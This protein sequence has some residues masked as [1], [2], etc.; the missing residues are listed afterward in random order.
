MAVSVAVLMILI[1]ASREKVKVAWDAFGKV[2]I[3]GWSK[4]RR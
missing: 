1:D 2:V 4:K 3:E